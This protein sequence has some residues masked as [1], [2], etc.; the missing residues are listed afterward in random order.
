MELQLA[1]GITLHFEFNQGD[2]SPAEKMTHDYPG[3]AEEL[4]FD[5]EIKIDS[6]EYIDDL[7]DL[8]DNLIEVNDGDC[9]QK[10]M[11]KE[12]QEQNQPEPY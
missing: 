5:Y 8:I 2:S 7:Q 6:I 3:C 1:D 11:E 12:F 9:I 10:L 4:V